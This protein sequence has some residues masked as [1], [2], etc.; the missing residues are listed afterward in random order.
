MYET[1][2]QI[3]PHSRPD[4]RRLHRRGGKARRL[5]GAN[6][7]IAPEDLCFVAETCRGILGASRGEGREASLGAVAFGRRTLVF[8]EGGTGLFLCYLDSPADEEVLSWLFG[9]VDPLLAAEGI[10]FHPVEET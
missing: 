7:A 2:E 1:F 9:R 8:R 6:S 10:A 4:R 3:A 5:G